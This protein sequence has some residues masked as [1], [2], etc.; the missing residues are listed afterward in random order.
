MMQPLSV[1][2]LV[3]LFFPLIIDPRKKE[4]KLVASGPPNLG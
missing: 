3:A 1:L 4:R 2:V